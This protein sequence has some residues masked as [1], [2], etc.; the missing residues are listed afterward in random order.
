M[1]RVKRFAALL[2]AGVMALSVLTGCGGSATA[3]TAKNVADALNDYAMRWGWQ[4]TETGVNIVFAADNNSDVNVAA[5]YLRD[6]PK[7]ESMTNKEYADE[8]RLNA[9]FKNIPAED[10]PRAYAVGV[11]WIGDKLINNNNKVAYYAVDLMD[12]LGSLFDYGCSSESI[13]LLKAGDSYEF[14]DAFTIKV[15]TAVVQVDPEDPNAK[16]LVVLYEAPVEEDLWTPPK[17]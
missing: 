16:I 15:S 8:I 4:D 17:L 14:G 6:H 3:I 9:K 2:L 12:R 5:A 1:K 13:Y 10:E 7:M 11:V